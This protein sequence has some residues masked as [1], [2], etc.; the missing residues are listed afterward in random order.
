MKSKSNPDHIRPRGQTGEGASELIDMSGVPTYE[1]GPLYCTDGSSGS[2]GFKGQVQRDCWVLWSA[3]R[4]C[5]IHQGGVH[6][7]RIWRWTK[8]EVQDR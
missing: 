1:S 8:L 7:E 6:A 4:Q 5:L 2:P 3:R